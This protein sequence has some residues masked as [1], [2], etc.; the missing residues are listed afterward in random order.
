MARETGGSLLCHGDEAGPVPD[1]VDKW[2]GE[3]LGSEIGLGDRRVR[4]AELRIAS[5]PVRKVMMKD[6]ERHL[7]QALRLQAA[8]LIECE[9]LRIRDLAAT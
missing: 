6:R 7:H 4:H 8:L 3:T 5:Y 2:R 1:I 9:F